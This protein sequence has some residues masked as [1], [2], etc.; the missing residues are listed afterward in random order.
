MTVKDAAKSRT[1]LISS[2]LD[3]EAGD[4]GHHLSTIQA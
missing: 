1:G 3:E 4:D 2:Y